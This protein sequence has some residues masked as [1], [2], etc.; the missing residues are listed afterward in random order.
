M[1]PFTDSVTLDIPV[2]DIRNMISVRYKDENG[3][4]RVSYWNNIWD[5]ID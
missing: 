3:A 1:A 4:D 5:F 2:H